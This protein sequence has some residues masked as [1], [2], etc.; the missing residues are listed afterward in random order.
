M[1]L[2]DVAA[3]SVLGA[4]LWHSYATRQV[5]LAQ[6]RARLEELILDLKR[7]NLTPDRPAG[8]LDRAE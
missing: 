1:Q 2:L 3:I 8:L 6:H 4:L 5:E 7:A